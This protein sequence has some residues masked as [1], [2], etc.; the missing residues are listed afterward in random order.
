MSIYLYVHILR[1][2]VVLHVVWILYSIFHWLTVPPITVLQCFLEQ[3][4][5]RYLFLD[6]RR[7]VGEAIGSLVSFMLIKLSQFC[8]II[9]IWQSS[10]TL[11]LIFS[12]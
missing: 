4:V 8:K 7:S 10:F 9:F 12:K 1:L 6:D 2:S 3:P 5:T 11:T